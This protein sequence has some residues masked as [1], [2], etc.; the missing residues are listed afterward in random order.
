MEGIRCALEEASQQEGPDAELKVTERGRPV[1]AEED[2]QEEEHNGGGA[3]EKEKDGGG[4]GAVG[5][6]TATTTWA[7]GTRTRA[8]PAVHRVMGS[9]GAPRRKRRR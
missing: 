9:A 1:E 3:E 2:G 7:A 5:R 6:R 4:G 8:V